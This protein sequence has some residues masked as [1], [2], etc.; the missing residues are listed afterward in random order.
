MFHTPRGSCP[1]CWRSSAPPPWLLST[2][3]AAT[4]TCG[5]HPDSCWTPQSVGSTAAW[6]LEVCSLDLG[7]GLEACRPVSISVAPVHFGF[8][9]LVVF[10]IGGVSGSVLLVITLDVGHHP[11]VHLDIYQKF[12]TYLSYI[13]LVCL[14]RSKSQPSEGPSF[15]GDLWFS[16]GLTTDHQDPESLVHV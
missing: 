15:G 14:F 13:I 12:C 11:I 10:H 3:P 2:W 1:R 5:R 4:V 16:L 9:C 7:S 6:R 8:C